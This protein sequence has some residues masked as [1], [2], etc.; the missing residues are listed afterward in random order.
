MLDVDAII[1]KMDL[2]GI[3][4]VALIPAMND[5]LPETPKVL[6]GVLRLLMNSR[7]H[8]CAGW[9]NDRFMTEEGDLKLR[10][11]I[12][13]IYASPDNQT[14]ADVLEQHPDRFLGWIFLNPRVMADPLDELE[15]WRHKPG[16]V[17]VKLHPH[18]HGYTTED[19]LPIAKRCEELR[20]PILI[21]LGFGE[22]GRWQ[23]LTDRCPKLRMI[24]AHAGMP[25]F[26]RIWP[27]IRENPNLRVDLSSPY[28]N[29]RIVRQVVAVIGPHRALFGTD[30]PYGFHESDHS[31]DYGHIKS[32]VERLPCRATDIDRIFGDNVLELL[33]EAR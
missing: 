30:A 7:L 32:W 5:P 10:G 9:L 23:V 16:F 24:F 15:R 22:R 13:K 18:W 14:V 28:L 12:Y 29:E 6:L 26:S 21:H 8:C 2:A 19:A 27:Y 4:K 33:S 1:A 31:Y 11:T 20:L 17:G 3:D 25:H